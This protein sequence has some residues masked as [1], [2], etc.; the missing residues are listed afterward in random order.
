MLRDVSQRGHRKLREV[1]DMVI[2]T[3]EAP[4]AA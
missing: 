1:A 3:G 2:L 4:S